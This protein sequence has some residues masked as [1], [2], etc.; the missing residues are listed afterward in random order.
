MFYL[1]LRIGPILV[2]FSRCKNQAN[3]RWDCGMR[4]ANCGLGK[5][6][7]KT[8]EFFDRSEIPNLS[9]HM[10]CAFRLSAPFL[11]LWAR[12]SS[13]DKH[14]IEESEVRIQKIKTGTSLCFHLAPGSLLHATDNGQSPLCLLSSI[15]LA[16]SPFHP[17]FALPP[18]SI[19][20]DT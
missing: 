3:P 14:S 8:A 10:P 19:L 15:L 18:T 2:V 7:A 11:Q 9:R 12:L 4:I 5:V 20:A 16:V 1:C 6:L 13:R 17:V